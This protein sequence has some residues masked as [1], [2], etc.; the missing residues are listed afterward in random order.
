MTDYSTLESLSLPSLSLIDSTRVL[1][2]LCF[3]LE[4][5]DLPAPPVP[6]EEFFIS[7]VPSQE[8]EASETVDLARDKI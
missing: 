8:V 2:E 4:L 5:R 1:A 7:M 6:E 3:S